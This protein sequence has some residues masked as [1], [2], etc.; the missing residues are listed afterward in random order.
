MPSW[1]VSG[2]NRE[3]GW[4]QKKKNI[5]IIVQILVHR[6]LGSQLMLSTG[7]PRLYRMGPH[8]SISSVSQSRLQ[9]SIEENIHQQ[10]IESKD[11]R[12]FL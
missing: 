2:R 11:G 10:D 1:S 9:Q 8:H 12:M 4:K 6:R 3:S 7:S 5:P